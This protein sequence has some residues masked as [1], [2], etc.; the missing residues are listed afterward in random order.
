AI[1]TGATID[2]PNPTDGNPE[3]IDDMLHA[4]VNSR[5]GFF[6]ASDPEVF[7]RELG[8]VLDDIIARV[9]ESATS[10]AASAAIL[11]SDTL[12]YVAGFRSGDWSG[13]M[14]AYEL[15]DDGTQGELYWDA[16]TGLATMAPAARRILTTNS[17]NEACAELQSGQVRPAQLTA[18]NTDMTGATDNLAADR[19]EWLRGGSVDGFRSR[20]DAGSRR[21][22][23]DII[24]S[25]PQYSGKIDFGYSMFA[26]T[27]GS[28][29]ITFRSQASYNDRSDV[30]YVGSNNG[31]FHAFNAEN[32]EELFAYMPSELLLP[33]TAGG[34]ARINRLMDP[35]YTHRYFVDGTAA[36]GDAYV[37][38][39][40]RTVAVGTMGA[41]G[42]T[43]FALDVTDPDNFN[44]SNVL[45]EFTHPDLGYNV[46]E[47]TISRMRDGSWAAVFGNGYNSDNHRAGLFIVPLHD[48]DAY[49]FINTGEGDASNPNGLASPRV[50]DWPSGDLSA[51][52]I[53]AGDLEGRVWKFDVSSTNT[54]QWTNNNNRSVLFQARD[55]GGT[56]QPITSRPAIAAHPTDAQALMVLFGTGSYFRTQDGDMDS[57]QIQTLYGLVDSGSAIGGRGDLL[58]QS[59][60]WQGSHTFNTDNGAISYELR[61]ISENP[62]NDEDGWFL[63]LVYDG[64]AEGERV[65]SEPTFPSGSVQDRVRF[66]TLIPDEDPC[67]AGRRGFIMDVDLVTGGTTGDAVFDLNQDGQV[68]GDDDV[69]GRPISGVGMG[70]GERI[71]IIR[72]GGTNLDNMYDGRGRNLQGLNNAGPAGRQSWMQ[73]R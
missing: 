9:E 55:P 57:P 12:L 60:E 66:S 16:E 71:T 5:G 20:T 1:T 46:S 50:T 59:I 34:P 36:V 56:P 61:E 10:S 27:E 73:I 15:N 43:V 51:R 64:N 32:G 31:L 8:G 21:L 49:T 23:G 37:G 53:Y 4:A 7:A 26:G 72:D 24:H 33:A 52:R 54:G 6:S 69:D 45:W 14:K 13:E 65:I 63:D 48:P 41:G 25:T 38:G 40:W 62:L 3:K 68:D 35:D 19:I 44:A 18:L 30:L 28:S 42:R 39:N 58:E 70:Q 11:Q 29:Y 47:P 17:A 67:G 2:W 22:L